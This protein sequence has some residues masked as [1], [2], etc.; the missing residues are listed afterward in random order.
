MKTENFTS[1]LTKDRLSLMPALFTV[2]H[3]F[4]T[5]PTPQQLSNSLQ[6]NPLI[7]DIQTLVDFLSAGVGVV[8]VGAIIVGGIQYTMAGDNPQAVSAAK[9]RIFNALIALVAFMLIFSFLQ[10]ILPGGIFK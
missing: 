10:Y 3:F 8:V 9:K 6:R 2:P 4:G 7:N 5:N 1:K